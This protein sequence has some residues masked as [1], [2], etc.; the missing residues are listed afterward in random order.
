MLSLRKDYSKDNNDVRVENVGVENV[1]AEN[2]G[3]E[4]VKAI[5]RSIGREHMR[6]AIVLNCYY[7]G[8]Y[9]PKQIHDYRE[10]EEEI[11][12]NSWY[13]IAGA[14][15][16]DERE[17]SRTGDLDYSLIRRVFDIFFPRV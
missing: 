5:L 15:F 12:S 8:R 3:V 2:V 7:S 14:L 13:E 11:T 17:L 4:N 6:L 1:K 9:T 16:L 10:K